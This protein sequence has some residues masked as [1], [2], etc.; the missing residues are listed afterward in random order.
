[1]ADKETNRSLSN[2]EQRR[3]TAFEAVREAHEQ[4][5]YTVV[6]RTVSIVKANIFAILLAIPVMA[7]AF[8][9]FFLKNRGDV[10]AFG[11]S[12][13]LV[14]LVSIFVLTVVHE[15]IHGITWGLAAENHFKSIEFGFMKE[16]L[17][18][19]CT[20]SEPLGRGKYILGA[21]MPLIVLGI[22]PTVIAI[23]HGSFLLLVIGVVMILA[24]GGDIL[25]VIKLLTYRSSAEEV[26]IYDHPTQA[27]CFIFEK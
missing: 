25:I 18:P 1:M 19:Y 27:G 14:F 5:G 8:L 23:F 15:L 17:T 6:E 10:R 3:L 26:L 12:G 22:I 9:L 21:L 13:S 11:L 16:Y 7:A 24:A 2:A 20:C 4:D